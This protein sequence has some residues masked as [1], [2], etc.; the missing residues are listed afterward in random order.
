MGNIR[1]ENWSAH[2]IRFVEREPGDWWAVATDVAKAL[3][4]VVHIG[5]NHYITIDQLKKEVGVQTVEDLARNGEFVIEDV[6][7]SRDYSFALTNNDRLLLI[8]KWWDVDGNAVIPN[9]ARVVS[10]LL[11]D[12][13]LGTALKQETT[14]FLKSTDYI[15]GPPPGQIINRLKDAVSYVRQ[16]FFIKDKEEN[17]TKKEKT[18]FV[19]LLKAD[20]NLIKIGRTTKLDE[21]IY[22]FTT[23]L[24]YKLHLVGVIKSERYIEIEADLHRTFHAK[25]KRGEWF[26]LTKEDLK[27]IAERFRL[28]ISISKAIYD[29][30]AN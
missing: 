27:N 17:L 24:P 20:N 30:Y 29:K 8:G 7:V 5:E 16:E 11:S 12:E 1:T 26:D 15:F 9:T 19:Y 3:G 10:D 4:C 22:H 25:R 21:R 2:E 18:G 13:K 6:K 28:D 23:K 14:K